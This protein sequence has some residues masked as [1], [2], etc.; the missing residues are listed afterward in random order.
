MTKKHY[1]AIAIIIQPLTTW[2][3]KDAQYIA[4]ELADY[5]QTDNP[6][7]NR[8]RFLEA[9]GVE[10]P[11]KRVPYKTTPCIHGSAGCIYC[12]EPN[13]AETA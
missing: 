2:N 8:T 4:N 6:K 7:F 12:K 3:E 5:F 1:E 10:Q 9:C 13:I 11:T